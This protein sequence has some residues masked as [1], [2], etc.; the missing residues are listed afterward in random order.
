MTGIFIASMATTSMNAPAP[1]RNNKST[2]QGAVMKMKNKKISAGN[3]LAGL[4]ARH[5]AAPPSRVQTHRIV[6]VARPGLKRRAPN[7]KKR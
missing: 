5:K 2:L 3:G 7:F 1:D 6:N 4:E